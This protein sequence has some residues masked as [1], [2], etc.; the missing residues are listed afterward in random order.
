[1]Y[2]VVNLLYICLDMGFIW[3]APRLVELDHEIL[4]Y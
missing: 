3:K 4:V 2:T 1:M